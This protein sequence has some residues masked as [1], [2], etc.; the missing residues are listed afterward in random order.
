MAMRECS[1]EEVRDLLPLLASGRLGDDA[2][3]IVDAHLAD[4]D[5]CRDE[6]ALLGR[7]RQALAVGPTVNAARIARAIPPFDGGGAKVV[8]IASRRRIA[9]AWRIA[10]AALLVIGGAG[11]VVAY[12]DSQRG[13]GAPGV[14]T[15]GEVDALPGAPP[16]PGLAEAAPPSYPAP[17]SA[18]PAGNGANAPQLTFGGGLD[19]LSEADLAALLAALDDTDVIP[20]AEPDAGFLFMSFEGEEEI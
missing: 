7:A 10:A 17:V 3:R 19:D 4:C 14:I 11:A 12:Q 18:V 16:A 20:A 15:A 1:N 9:P 6:L 13:S 5:A 8:P 2:R